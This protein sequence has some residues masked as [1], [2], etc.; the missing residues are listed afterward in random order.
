MHTLYK[1]T[2]KLYHKNNYFIILL[3]LIIIIIIIIVIIIVHN[4]WEALVKYKCLEFWRQSHTETNKLCQKVNIKSD[5]ET[6]TRPTYQLQDEYAYYTSVQVWCGYQQQSTPR[7]TTVLL[8]YSHFLGTYLSQPLDHNT[9][10][11]TTIIRYK[12]NIH[13]RSANNCT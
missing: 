9:V 3:L 8:H 6:Q 2:A 1:N 10:R 5:T 11:D 12:N 4:D 13:I 7:A